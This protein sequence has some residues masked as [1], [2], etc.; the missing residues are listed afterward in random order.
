[1]AQLLEEMARPLGPSPRAPA[2]NTD[3]CMRFPGS[4]RMARFV[5]LWAKYELVLQCSSFP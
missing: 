2:G 1:M 5:N 4:A 3:P